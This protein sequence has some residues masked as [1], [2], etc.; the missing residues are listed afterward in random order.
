M[1]SADDLRRVI[2]LPRPDGGKLTTVV[3]C[4]SL[5]HAAARQLKTQSL[6]TAQHTGVLSALHLAQVLH[7]QGSSDSPA[8]FFV[9]RGAQTA[10]SDDAT[11]GLASS[12]LIGFLRVANNELPQFR[13]TL[14]DLDPICDQFRI[15]SLLKEISIDSSESEVAFRNSQ[16]LV[17]RMRSVR[18]EELTLRSRNAVGPKGQIVPYRLQTGKPGVLT[19]LSL[20]ETHRTDPQADE[21]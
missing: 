11:S 20:N 15:D 5:D 17:H 6:L 12:P 21:I 8:V 14:I 18:E 13:W 16:R 19:R 3:H 4:W 1:E 9:S 10:I 7:S 2:E